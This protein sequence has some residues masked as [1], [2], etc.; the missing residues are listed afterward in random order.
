V[1]GQGAGWPVS[2]TFNGRNQITTGG[3]LYDAAGNVLKDNANCY[4]YDAENRVTS[5]APQASGVC[6]AT[7]MSY[8]YDPEGRRVARLQNGAIVKQDYYDSAGIE[9]AETDG[10]GTLLRAEIYAGSRHLATWNSS[11][12]GSTYFNHADELGTERVRSFGSGSNAGQACEKI[13]S[14]PF[15]DGQQ[16]APLNGGCGDPSPDHFT[17]LERDAESGL[18]HTLNRQFASSYGRWLTPDPAG[19]KAVTLADPQTLNMYEYAHNNPTT[20]TDTTGLGPEAENTAGGPPADA[21]TTPD[22][23]FGIGDGQSKPP[24]PKTSPAESI[25]ILGQK[26]SVTYVGLTDKEQQQARDRLVAA[27]AA[28]NG[29]ANKLT[30]EEKSAIGEVNT[31]IV[32]DSGKVGAT[33]PHEATLLFRDIPK[34]SVAWTASLIPHE[35]QHMTNRGIYTGINLWRDEQSA[36]RVQLGVGSKIGFTQKERDWLGDWICDGSSIKMQHHM[37][38]GYP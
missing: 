14:L 9:I 38:V 21:N 5:V 24:D 36:G 2:L 13:T 25:T 31:I 28:I 8:L 10:N 20:L 3:Y 27:A 6:G 33:G 19:E 37:V 16:T 32:T 12:G 22:Y 23:G 30:D 29:A 11:G 1:Q 17:G 35:G 7:T 34:S 26:V 4:T 15:G 18:D